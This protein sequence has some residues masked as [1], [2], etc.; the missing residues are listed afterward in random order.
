MD[1]CYRK[2]RDI[3]TKLHDKISEIT[4]LENQHINNRYS[5]VELQTFRKLDEKRD[6]LMKQYNACRAE[7]DKQYGGTTRSIIYRS[8]S[9]TKR[10]RRQ[11]TRNCR[12]RTRSHRK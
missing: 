2:C 1:D 10:R 3:A 8:K 6:N 5:S 9:K 12:R 4:V 11:R 7:C